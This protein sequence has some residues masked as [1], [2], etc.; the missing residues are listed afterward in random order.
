M[1][2]PQAHSS[3]PLGLVASTR[4]VRAL[5]NKGPLLILGSSG[6]HRRQRAGGEKEGDLPRHSKQQLLPQRHHRPGMRGHPEA[7]LITL[8]ERLEQPGSCLLSIQMGT[9]SVSSLLLHLQS[10]QSLDPGQHC[11]PEAHIPTCL[12]PRLRNSRLQDTPSRDSLGQG[13]AG[14]LAWLTSAGI[15]HNAGTACYQIGLSLKADLACLGALPQFHH[16]LNG[17][18]NLTH[19]FW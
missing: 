7:V 4:R 5:C 11:S 14:H 2:S 15:C 17:I 18:I 6:G 10:A 16:L 9:K 8:P 19:L 3:G 1:S 12:P 13:A